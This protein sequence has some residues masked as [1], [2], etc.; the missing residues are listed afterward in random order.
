MDLG[1]KFRMLHGAEMNTVLG[2]EKKRTYRSD[3]KTTKFQE[4]QN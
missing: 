4:G 3:N 1:D 2:G